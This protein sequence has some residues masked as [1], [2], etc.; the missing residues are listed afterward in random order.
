VN[1]LKEEGGGE[2]VHVLVQF[3]SLQDYL[4]HVCADRTLVNETC[5]CWMKCLK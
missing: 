5:S 3:A 4:I 2:Y 1:D